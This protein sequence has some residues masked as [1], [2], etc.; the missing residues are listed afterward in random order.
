[1]KA[2]KVKN[3]FGIIPEWKYQGEHYVFTYDNELYMPLGIAYDNNYI[4]HDEWI[5]DIDYETI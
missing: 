1:M 2:V 5:E 3:L 4:V